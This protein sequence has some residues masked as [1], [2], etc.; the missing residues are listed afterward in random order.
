MEHSPSQNLEVNNKTR[1]KSRN[2]H[3]E[4]M[5]NKEQNW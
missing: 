3:P 4:N 2:L 1:L 5:S